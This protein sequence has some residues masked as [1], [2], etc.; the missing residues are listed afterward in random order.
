MPSLQI[1]DQIAVLDL[2]SEENRFSDDW[3]TEVES[4]IDQ[5]VAQQALGFVT[6]GSGKFYSNGLD[7]DE[8]ADD[9]DLDPA[10]LRAVQAMYGKVLALPMPTVAAVNGH[11]FGAGALLSMAHDYRIMR[12]DRGFFCFP[13]V[14]VGIVFP[15]GMA[16]L[17]QSKLDPR[18][19]RTAMLSGHRYAA[20]K[21]LELGLVDATAP[22]DQLMEQA[23][24]LAASNAVQNPA[25]LG[26]I[27][28]V[29]YADV[30]AKLAGA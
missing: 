7:V 5:A 10:Y 14:Q 19:A 25:A 11:A 6:I 21:A 20:D 26:K 12:E 13:E 4:L 15:P 22:Q 9:I 2:G 8:S 24:A 1:T 27:K 29:M 16:A 18:T 17:A 23:R 28:E 3:V 30:L